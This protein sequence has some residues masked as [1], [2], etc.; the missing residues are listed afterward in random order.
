MK[1]LFVGGTGIISSACVTEA[2]STGYEVWTLNRG[3]SHLANQV[4]ERALHAD[5]SDEDQVRTVLAGHDFDAVIQWTAYGPEQ[6][7]RDI[8][9]YA[10]AGQ[11][12]FISSASAYEK[13][14]SHWLTTEATPLSNPF[15]R[16]SREKIACEE[17]LVEA[18][19]S[20]GFPMTIIRPSLTYGVSQIPVCVGSWERPFT[21]V[22]R[23]R[24]GAPIIVPGDGTSIWTLTHN[25]DLARGLIPLL[26]R[27]E[28]IGEAF[29]I[30]SNEALNW[31]QIFMLVG[32]AAGVEPTIIHV[33]TDGIVAADPSQLGT[34]W[35]D[36]V[37]STV[38][39]NAKLRMLVPEFRCV[40]PFDQGIRETVAWF[41][42]DPAR[43]TIDEEANDSWDRIAAIYIDALAQARARAS[44]RS[45]A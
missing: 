2:L 30:T 12:V 45:R 40:V 4:G 37:H 1:V 31:N 5:A 16:Y 34:L 29:H 27:R 15:W 11:Y 39:D 13:P 9:L 43:Q 22:D 10:D 25:T 35:G 17:R 6:V 23:M 26:G 3:T 24:R 8:R 19:A 38:F 14:P 7:E 42:A 20:T 21:I 28:A 32:E 33:P 36:K 18:F 41:D 44:A